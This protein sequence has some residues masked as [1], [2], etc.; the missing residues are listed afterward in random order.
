MAIRLSVP[1]HDR[2]TLE[3]LAELFGRYRGDR[4]VCVELE[5]RG[6]D[7][8]LKVC[9]DLGDTLIQPS[10]RLVEEVEQLCGKGT[11]SWQ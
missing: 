11:V 5:L 4:H 8:P 1:P 10:D 6:Y 9:A 2:G 7:Q 3:A